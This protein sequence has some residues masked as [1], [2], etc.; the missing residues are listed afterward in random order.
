MHWQRTIDWQPGY[1]FGYQL[2]S[3]F[4]RQDNTVIMINERP[5]ET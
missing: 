5:V 2:I 3:K 1:H 4:V